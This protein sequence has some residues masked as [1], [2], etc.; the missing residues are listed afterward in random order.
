ML[1]DSVAELEDV[2][3]RLVPLVGQIT[4]LKQWLPWKIVRTKTEY[5]MYIYNVVL[6]TLGTCTKPRESY[7]CTHVHAGVGVLHINI[8]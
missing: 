1:N 8:V 3:G 6:N 4:H 2:A 5:G 7:V